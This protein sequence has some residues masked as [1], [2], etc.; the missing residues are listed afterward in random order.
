MNR[1]SEIEFQV[2]DKIYA[3]S[4]GLVPACIRVLSLRFI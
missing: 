4:V 2:E 3:R 1:I